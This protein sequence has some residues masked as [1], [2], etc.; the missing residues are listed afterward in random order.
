MRLRE[1]HWPGDG[2]LSSH[3]LLPAVVLRL[4]RGWGSLRAT[5]SLEPA[6]P[7]VPS[8]VITPREPPRRSAESPA[9]PLPS[10]SGHLPKCW[11]PA[12]I[13]RARSAR[14]TDSRGCGP[15]GDLAPDW[16][17]PS[18]AIRV[19]F[20]SSPWRLLSQSGPR[21]MLRTAM[22][23]LTLGFF[24][25]AGSGWGSPVTGRLSSCSTFMGG[26]FHRLLDRYACTGGLRQALPQRPATARVV[27]S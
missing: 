4:L 9:S 17:S 6:P 13:P 10:M 19:E 24:G 21:V 12:R 26:D 27:A 7:R 15:C 5:R 18:C 16:P 11:A 20:I 8:R 22:G 2:V 1:T 23:W 3:G 25:C 14:T